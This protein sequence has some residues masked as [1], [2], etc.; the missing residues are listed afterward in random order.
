MGD[1]GHKVFV[2]TRRASRVQ[3]WRD[4]GLFPLV[5]DV[6]RPSTLADLPRAETVL[7]AVGFD[8]SAGSSAG[9]VYLAGLRA[10]LD[11]LPDSVGRFL[12]IS[13]TGVFG[14]ADGGWVDEESV[15]QPTRP[16]GKACWEAERLLRSTPSAPARLSCG[17][18]AFTVR[19]GFPAGPICCGASRSGCLQAAK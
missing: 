1:A 16:T 7:Y 6:T 3:P 14:Q 11:A 2:V 8:H 10:V 13:S 12:Y 18:R 4:Q 15:C 19:S 9:A 5:A 17:W